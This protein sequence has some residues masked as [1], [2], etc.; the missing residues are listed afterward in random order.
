M[1]KLINLTASDVMAS[2]IKSANNRM[3]ALTKQ[4]NLSK[5]YLT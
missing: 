5:F 1:M 4:Y 2:R 3:N